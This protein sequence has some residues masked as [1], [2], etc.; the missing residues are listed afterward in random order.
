MSILKKTFGKEKRWVNWKLKKLKGKQTKIPYAVT[1][2]MASSTD[3]KDWSTYDV[4]KK[5]SENI[6]IVFTPQQDLLGI[7]IDH[8]INKENNSIQHEQAEKIANLIL[9]ADTYTEISPSGE[10]LHLFLKLAGGKLALSSNKRA[11]FEAY[12]SG[13]Y[14]TV[15]EKVY[16]KESRDVRTVSHEEALRLLAIIDYPWKREGNIENTSGSN[17]KSKEIVVPI[18]T[19]LSTSADTAI[20]TLMFRSKH[21]A[22]I[23]ALYEG[24]ISKYKND[25]SSADM[26]WCS[27]AAFWTKKDAAQIERLWLASPLGNREKTQSRKDYRI[28]TIENAIYNCKEVY[29]P[30]GALMERKIAEAAIDLVYLTDDKGRKVYVLNTENISRILRSH[31]EFAGRFRYDAFGAL[32]EWK[33]KDKWRTL[34]DNDDVV[35]QTRIS[36]LFP[37]FHRI[38]KQMVHDAVL[39]IAKENTMDSAIDYMRGVKWDGTPR[40]DNWLNSVYGCPIDAY[41]TAVG[42]NWMKGLVKRIIEPGCKFDFVLVLEGPQGSKKSTSLHVLGRDWHLETIIST[43]TKDFFMQMQRKAIIEFAEGETLSRTEVKRMKA[44]ITMQFDKFRPPYERV[45]QD[46]PRRCVFAM[47]TNQEEYLKDETGNRRWLPVRVLLEEANTEWLKANRDQLFAEA[48]HRA[49]EK[50]ETVY[51][52]PKEETKIQQEAR[53]VSDPNAEIISHWYFETL[54]QDDRDNGITVHQVH[55][56]A[57]GN[58]YAGKELKKWQEMNITEVLRSH[59]KLERRQTMLHG[60]RATRWYEINRQVV[61]TPEEDLAH[62]MASED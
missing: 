6:G 54:G 56:Q 15:T 51:E 50:N 7:D 48:Y 14:F 27:H 20:L 29:E 3:E 28:R 41:H 58:M 25:A 21:G 17:I 59:L 43:D 19:E 9:E 8:C 39:K 2:R 1:G 22:D 53:R 46:F 35:I 18:S 33:V 47:T 32:Y 24:D 36:V 26:A 44:I 11:P 31:P 52:F 49:I 34:E 60:V 23:K 40:L 5:S 57:L 55:A 13:R 10:G 62:F 61:R 12:T 37:Y 42:A 16:G 38:G 45:S 4:A 30:A